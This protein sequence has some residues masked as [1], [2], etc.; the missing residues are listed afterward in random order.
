VTPLYEIEKW[1]SERFAGLLAAHRIPGAAIAVAVGDDVIEH[2][3]GVLS[4]ATGV[5]V[6]TDSLFQIGSITKL[7]TADLVMQL[8]EEG[9]L[10]LG[11]PVR[12]YL[13]GFRV[14]DEAAITVRQL[15]THTSGFAGDIFTDTG[16]NDDAI[17]RYVD[18]LDD[19]EQ[20]FPPGE[21]FSYNNAGYVVLG[22]I[23]EVLRGKPFAACLQ[24]GLIEPLGLTH[25]ALGAERAILFRAAVGHIDGRPAPVWNL[26]PAHAPAGSLLAMAP[27]ELLAFA[28]MHL[29]CGT[30]PQGS[31]VISAQTTVA[32][33]EPQVRLPRLALLGDAWGLGWELEHW[34]TGTV[35][36]HTGNT[37]GQSAALRI[38]PAAGLSIA[39]LMNGGEVTAAYREIFGFLLR[40]LAGVQV[41]PLDVPPEGRIP[42]DPARY[43]G[44]YSSPA[45]DL[46]VSAD[47]D[48]RVW[49]DQRPKGMLA[50]L[51]DKPERVE[52]VRLDGDTFLTAEATEGVHRT[53]V[54]LGDDGHG[55]AQYLHGGR[56]SR[57]VER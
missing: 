5:D 4:T 16:L 19:A 46:V 25:T 26:P 27:R 18:G 45:K 14:A 50:E 29:R 49:L 54:F 55:K 12:R 48:G 2:A 41:P 43:A 47:D 31:P 51:G 30:G 24:E 15:L 42:V 40:E 21:M 53:V 44:E 7:W 52:I 57:R 28:R 1:L 17:E 20:V 35:I 34:P 56:V 11:A 6:T 3:A 37:L 10:E 39:L 22:R 23:V 33:L 32:V 13:P 9:R 36:G 38:V 8:A